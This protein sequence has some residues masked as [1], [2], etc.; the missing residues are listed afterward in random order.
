M[1]KPALLCSHAA[2]IGDSIT[3]TQLTNLRSLNICGTA[4]SFEKLGPCPSGVCCGLEYPAA[5]LKRL[6]DAWLSRASLPR[7]WRGLLT[8][9]G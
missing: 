8:Y 5:D 4:F 1:I 3:W 9:S 6:Q 2:D 7:R